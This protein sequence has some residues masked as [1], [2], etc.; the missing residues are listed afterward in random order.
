MQLVTVYSQ[1]YLSSFDLLSSRKGVR[2]GTCSIICRLVLH[3]AVRL[4]P[5]DVYD[6][7][8]IDYYLTADFL[9]GSRVDSFQSSI[10][11]TVG[12]PSVEAR[13]I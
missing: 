4:L 7:S 11:C 8:S 3:V 2:V 1:K 6:F 9:I 13:A 12:L 10:F 5:Y